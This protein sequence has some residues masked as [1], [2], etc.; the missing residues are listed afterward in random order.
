MSEENKHDFFN[1]CIYSRIIDDYILGKEIIPDI[2][3]AMS[4][5]VC[6]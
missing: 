4:D 1:D 3:G 5:G 6:I 2:S